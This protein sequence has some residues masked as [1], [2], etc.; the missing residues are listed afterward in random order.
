ML[1]KELRGNFDERGTKM[2]TPSDASAPTV[3]DSF[4]LLDNDH[5]GFITKDDIM[6]Y[7]DETIRQYGRDP[8]SQEASNYRQVVGQF[9]EAMQAAADKDNDQRITKDEY[10][11]HVSSKEFGESI[12]LY[13]DAL[14]E[15]A[16]SDD[17]QQLTKEEF[18]RWGA[19]DTAFV[20]DVFGRY[21]QDGDGALTKS[22][23]REYMRGFLRGG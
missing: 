2:T 21:D 3:V 22:E 11:D 8:D 13:S 1:T 5:D 18:A 7:G 14:F 19:A 15:L 17:N 6:A 4:D 12:D 9:W 23:Y 16:N 20:D 10:V